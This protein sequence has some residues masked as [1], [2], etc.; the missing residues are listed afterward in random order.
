MNIFQRY[1]KEY[2]QLV[3]ATW[4]LARKRKPRSKD[5]WTLVLSHAMSKIK[6]LHRNR[7]DKD[8]ISQQLALLWLEYYQSYQNKRPRTD[9]KTYILRRS[10]WGLR[11]WLRKEMFNPKVLT[12]I[13]LK[14]TVERNEHTLDLYWLLYGDKENGPLHML[15]AYERYLLYLRHVQGFSIDEISE[16]VHKCE[17]TVRVKLVTL[18]SKIRSYANAEAIASRSCDRRD[19]IYSGTEGREDCLPRN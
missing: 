13:G 6:N 9:L 8:D 16:I 3:D 17:K 11:D 5:K 1:E 4:L 2:I 12:L 7:I 14:I 10:V 15:T 19:G 18:L